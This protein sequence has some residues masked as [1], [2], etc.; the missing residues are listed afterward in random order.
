MVFERLECTEDSLSW[1][2]QCRGLVDCRTSARR[3]VGHLGGVVVVLGVRDRV[4]CKR[5]ALRRRRQPPKRPRRGA[6]GAWSRYTAGSRDGGHPGGLVVG[7]G[8][9]RR[10]SGWRPSAL[11]PLPPWGPC[12]GAGAAAAVFGLE[13]RLRDTQADVSR[14]PRTPHLWQCELGG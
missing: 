3:D 8:Q 13:A 7:P 5:A 10:C 11:R 4:H 14:P 2:S 12:R 9:Q 1:C 6:R